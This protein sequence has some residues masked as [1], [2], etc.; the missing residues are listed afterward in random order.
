MRSSLQDPRN[1]ARKMG[2]TKTFEQKSTKETKGY[3]MQSARPDPRTAQTSPCET[4]TSSLRYLRCL[5][6]KIFS[7]LLVPPC[8]RKFWC[9][10]SIKFDRLR[11]FPIIHGL[12]AIV[13]PFCGVFEFDR[14][15]SSSIEFDAVRRS[16]VPILSPR[17]V[18][19]CKPGVF[20]PTFLLATYA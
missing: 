3:R 13:S 11:P 2:N 12:L 9:K 15:R 14:V 20:I 4:R 5:L 16:S 10:S 7:S 8:R 19:R 18:G 6:F 17:R 1:P